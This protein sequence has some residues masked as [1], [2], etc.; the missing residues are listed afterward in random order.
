MVQRA[1]CRVATLLLSGRW[2]PDGWASSTAQRV[3]GTPSVGSSVES[4]QV[5]LSFPGMTAVPWR[6]LMCFEV[7]LVT[8]SR[9]RLP[10][11]A[12]TCPRLRVTG[13][14][15]FRLTG[16]PSVH[17]M[18][19]RVVGWFVRPTA[20][21]LKRQHVRS[22]RMAPPCLPGRPFIHPMFFRSRMRVCAFLRV[23]LPARTCSVHGASHISSSR[24]P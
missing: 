1:T 21:P 4:Q 17:P 20:C 5:C 24:L 10:A 12:S 2:L 19:F 8:G 7:D 23:P 18:A 13:V 3:I 16:E 9:V 15:C 14:S 11:H 22:A 6:L